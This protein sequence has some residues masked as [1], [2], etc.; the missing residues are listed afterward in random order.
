MG[1]PVAAR[2]FEGYKIVIDGEQLCTAEYA[3]EHGG[4]I[5]RYWG[6]AKR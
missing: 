1:F 2:F 6:I 3:V 4:E 5:F